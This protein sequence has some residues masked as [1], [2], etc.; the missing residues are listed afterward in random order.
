M[1]KATR[2]FSEMPLVAN[3]VRSASSANMSNAVALSS[4]AESDSYKESGRALIGA[5]SPVGGRR[6]SS[7]I[8]TCWRC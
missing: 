7:G 6:V 4:A 3:P 8:N 2:S 1:L 5:M